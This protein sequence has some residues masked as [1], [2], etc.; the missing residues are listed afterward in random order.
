MA[1]S[2]PEAPLIVV[3]GVSGCG[4]STLGALIADRLALPFIDADSLHPTSNVAKMAAGTPLTDD[5]RWPWLARVGQVLTDGRRTGAG[6][7]VACSALKRSYREAI[8]AEAP[9]VLFVHLNGTKEVL[10]ARLQGRSGHFMPSGLLDSQLATLEELAADE[11]GVVV[12]ISPSVAVILTDAVTRIRA[13]LADTQVVASADV[14]LRD[15]TAA[16]QTALCS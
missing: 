4:K 6:A 5:D 15:F 9:G 2:Y 7:V 1:R 13:R 11:P 14:V 16:E 8:L 3:M 12:D 10:S